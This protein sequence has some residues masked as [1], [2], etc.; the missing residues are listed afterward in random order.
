MGGRLVALCLLSLLTAAVTS[1]NGSAAAPASLVA[2]TVDYPRAAWVPA[3]PSNYT[4][5]SR[6]LDYP[7]DMIVIHDIEGSYGSA[8]KAFQDPNR[9]GSS[10]YVIGY[11]GQVTQMVSEHDVAWH[12]G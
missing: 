8:I 12:A 4:V 10:H 6:P 9:H 1:T 2:A 11:H 5:A 3:A 7:V